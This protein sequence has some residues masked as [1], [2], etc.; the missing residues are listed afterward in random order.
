M[1]TGWTAID[2]AEDSVYRDDFGRTE[3]MLRGGVKCDRAG[4]TITVKWN[5]TTLGFSDIPQ[6]AGME[7]EATIDKAASIT[8]K[9]PQSEKI[10]RYAR[11][12]YLPE[13]EPGEHTAVLQV[14]TLP[15]GSSFYAG[16]VLVV[17]K[18]NP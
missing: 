11:F 17:G 3:A 18:V 15:A 5:G 8:I 2:T 10:H 12:F 13:Q 7:V 4:E 14:K 1:S 6:G 9:R 16:Q